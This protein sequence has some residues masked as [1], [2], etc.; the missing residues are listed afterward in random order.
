MPKDATF[1]EYTEDI[2]RN[3]IN[4]AVFIDEEAYFPGEEEEEHQPERKEL[5]APQYGLGSTGISIC[6]HRSLT[7]VM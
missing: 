2:V 3:F 5:L 7:E 6:S 4:T 1:L